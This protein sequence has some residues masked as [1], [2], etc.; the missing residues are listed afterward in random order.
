MKFQRAIVPL[1][2]FALALAV[3]CKPTDTG[4]KTTGPEKIARVTF[5]VGK[6]T[7]EDVGK[8][9]TDK[10]AKVR[11][12]RFGD[13][14]Y[15]GDLIRTG[16][17]AGLEIFVK[18]HGI[19][20]L[21][22]NAELAMSNFS[23]KSARVNVR[24]GS[25]GFFLKKQSANRDFKVSTPTAIASV[26]GTTFLVSVENLRESRV[27]LFSGAVQVKDRANATVDLTER[28]EIV[29]RENAKISRQMIRP[30]SARSLRLIKGLAVFHKN[31]IL[32]YNTL[33]DEL[34]KS[35]A[36]RDLEVSETVKGRYAKLRDSDRP[37]DAVRKAGR[38]DE[39]IIRKDTQGDPI[40]IP[41]KTYNE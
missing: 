35:R 16:K 36:V 38:A 19:L 17:G 18:G 20:R 39:N 3:Y 34:K 37:K 13:F 4:V 33:V 41:S 29:I 25:V 12:V 9:S 10:P 40:K 22:E 27:A 1:T 2:A 6:V 15:P 28:G 21:A 5:L 24:K 11:V 23:E 30:L 32:E 26:R 8:N 14:L 7:A 31:N